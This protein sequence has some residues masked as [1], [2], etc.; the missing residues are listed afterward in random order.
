L[1]TRLSAEEAYVWKILSKYAGPL[2]RDAEDRFVYSMVNRHWDEFSRNVAIPVFRVIS[3]RKAIRVLQKQ[4]KRTPGLGL[5][6]WGAGASAEVN[7]HISVTDETK[8]WDEIQ[9]RIVEHGVT[10]IIEAVNR[11]KTELVY[12]PEV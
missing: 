2:I 4:P 8:Q 7:V 6:A 10:N 3:A 11:K 5:R 9:S 12:D 1:L